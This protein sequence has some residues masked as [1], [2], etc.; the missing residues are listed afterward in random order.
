VARVLAAPSG[1]W[2][3]GAEV[4]LSLAG[5]EARCAPPRGAAPLSC[6][7]A[8]PRAAAEGAA[9]L[10]GALRWRGAAGEPEGALPLS[11]APP[12]DLLS[13]AAWAWGEG[14]RAWLRDAGFA[15]TPAPPG[16]LS[17]PPPAVRL[18]ALHDTPAD[19]LDDHDWGALR[20]WV[21][22]GGTLLLSGRA[23]AFAEGDWLGT[24]L[25]ALSPLSAR[26]E[27]EGRARLTFLLDASGSVSREAGGVGVEALVERAVAAA[28]ALP[29]ED[30]VALLSFDA[31]ARLALPP[32]PRAQLRVVSAPREGRGGSRLAPALAEAAAWL[33]DELNVWVLLSDGQVADDEGELLRAWGA[34]G[35]R[36]RDVRLLWAQAPGPHGAAPAAL[37]ALLRAAGGRA[38]PWE[39]L[40]PSALLA[41]RAPRAAEGPPNLSPTRAAGAWEARVG[42]APPPA[43]GWARA[44]LKPEARLLA[45]LEGGA[46]L[47]AEWDVGAGR[48]IALATD[49]WA[50]SASQR[51]AL[52][53]P[54][55]A[56]RP[57]AWGAAW[58]EAGLGEGAGGGAEGGAGGGVGGVVLARGG[59]GEGGALLRGPV[60]ALGAGEGL[61]ARWRP[62]LGGLSALRGLDGG[63]VHARL[64]ELGAPLL[65][66]ADPRGPQRLPLPA[67]PPRALDPAR[68]EGALR[69]QGGGLLRRDERG[70]WRAEDLAA[71]ARAAAPPAPPPAW[72]LWAALLAVAA[73]ELAAEERARRGG[74]G[75]GG[76]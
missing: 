69:A 71:L 24:P 48:V 31:A 46:P 42:G 62:L 20:R 8:L 13:P 35:A 47:L 45:R 3:A 2:G 54:A 68:V 30:E 17:A 1:R 43:R 21:E 59:P 55:L 6:A 7:L 27:V 29:E 23:R 64:L 53:A 40:T 66:S 76:A 65:T 60:V 26:P 50:L 56:E 58:V 18:I 25:D 63:D 4:T 10:E 57:G 38:L 70:A 51:R 14:A 34:L 61:S 49:D 72:W 19:A 39:G 75:G 16:A 5:R 52:L 28:G 33:G 12:R 9:R 67:P 32:T 41:A 73:A 22:G 15:L 36:A 74:G 11:W 44:R 37:R